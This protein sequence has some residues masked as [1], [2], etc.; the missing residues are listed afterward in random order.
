VTPEDFKRAEELLRD[1]DA[2]DCERFSSR[3]GRELLDTAKAYRNLLEAAEALGA[4]PEGYCFCSTNS[5]G[6]D[7]KVHEPECRDLRAALADAREHSSPQP[8]EGDKS[9]AEPSLSI[10]TSEASS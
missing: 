8:T 2:E 7:S 10:P 9:R 4:M 5:I 1:P 3:Y 6:D